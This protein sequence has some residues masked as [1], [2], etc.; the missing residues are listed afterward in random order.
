MATDVSASFTR[1]PKLYHAVSSFR[2]LGMLSVVLVS[3]VLGISHGAR[4]DGYVAAI[5]P[6]NSFETW[7]LKDNAPALKINVAGW[8]PNWGWTSP[9]TS[10]ARGTGNTI[11]STAPFTLN[12]KAGE[13]INVTC[14]AT[15]TGPTTIEFRYTLSAT[16]DIP[17]TMLIAGIGLPDKATK[18]QMT[19]T[20]AGKDSTIP[21]PNGRNGDL[22]ETSKV[23]IETPNA[24]NFT[25]AIDPP[26]AVGL[27]PAGVRVELAT[28]VFKAGEQTV[29]LTL[30]SPA[31]V[32]FQVSE[33]DVD[34]NVKHMAGPDWF[35]FV[36][37]GNS[38]PAVIGM[39]DWLD[40]PAGKHGSVHIANDHF[41]FEDG[42][43][44]KFWG[45]NLAYAACAPE[46]ADAD[47]TALRFAHY[48]VNA[49]RLHK[50]TGTGWE[51]IGDPNDCTKLDPKG[52]ENFDYFASQLTAQGVYYGFSHTFAM[53]LRPGNKSRVAGYDEIMKNNKGN[54]YSI[55]NIAEDVQDLLIEQ[56]VSLLKHRNPH[57]GKTYAEDPALCYIELQ[58]EDDIFF[59][60][61]EG[62]MKAAPTYAEKLRVR[63]ADWLK[64]KYGAQDKLKQAWGDALKGNESLE[65]HNLAFQTN[66]WFLSDANLPKAAPGERQ[67]LL[68]CAAF[69]HDVQNTFYSRF[70]KAIRQ[71]GYK[72]PLV[73]SPW[74]APSGVPHY[75]NL[76]SDYLVGYIDRHDYF[77]SHLDDT[78]LTHPGSGYLSSG[79]Q[80]VIDRPFGLS[81]WVTCYPALYSADGPVIVAAY[82]MGLQNW[83]SS[84]EFQSGS[85]RPFNSDAGGLPWNIWNVDGPTQLGQYPALARMIYRHD[86][87]PGDVISVRKI[88]LPELQQGKFSFT[89]KI[90]Q[91]GDIKTFGGSVPS[92]ALAVG[93]CLVQFTDKPEPSILPDMSRYTHDKVI[94]S[95]TGQLSWDASGKGFF[96]INTP[97]TKA[98]VG[99][100]QDKTLPLGDITLASHSPYVS[101]I[102]TALQKNATLDNAGS[103][104][105]TA[106]ARTS[107]TGFSYHAF[108]QSIIDNGKGP[109]MLEPVKA[110][111]T[112]A[113]RAIV[114]VHVLDQDGRR[115]DKTLPM[116]GNTVT[117]DTAR[118]HT[119]YYEVEFRNAGDAGP[120]SESGYRPDAD[121]LAHANRPPFANLTAV[122]T[123]RKGAALQARTYVD[124]FADL[125][126]IFRQDWSRTGLKPGYISFWQVLTFRALCT[127][128]AP[129]PGV[130]RF[131]TI[132]VA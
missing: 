47:A 92:A 106:V 119:I 116:E 82:G 61:L 90:E 89:D 58:N 50:F 75:Y 18:G 48:G 98:V 102:V 129:I 38:A 57:T 101:L 108:D 63:Y 95:T 121:K 88:S 40:K 94:T 110:T 125:A 5:S 35:P 31:N 81:E 12:A 93:R 27:Q 8:G 56:V 123:V 51:G 59:Y 114:A 124:K 69:Y 24:G 34:G 99:F 36:A 78:M 32:D 71:A 65:S 113:K 72:G 20:S 22:G 46:K 109:I 127:V 85:K 2:Q 4:G 6:Q 42:V 77:G 17:L 41:E 11:T 55:I 13:K 126:L 97:G 15:K 28:K 117:L 107:N 64:A 104:L 68:D 66:P 128:K 83:S 105:I 118:D 53:R 60:T 111:I 29:T 19:I 73:G 86:I 16:R 45:T 43:P 132:V 54:T 103:A 112:F 62:A 76:R 21:F 39:E 131:N 33:K 100:A 3:M 120:R 37:K 96:T 84:Y 87:R 30:T 7:V 49:V 44:V 10:Q 67:R 1:S 130:G 25:L 26:V 9:P 70:A 23:V 74:Q 91:Q 79:L 52:L 14:V 80:Q 115:T 122:A